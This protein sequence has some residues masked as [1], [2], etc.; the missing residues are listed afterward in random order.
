MVQL[1]FFPTALAANA[2]ISLVA[3]HTLFKLL[4][5]LFIVPFTGRFARLIKRLV[6]EKQSP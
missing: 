6:P 5:V 2:E 3:F 1:K 4:G